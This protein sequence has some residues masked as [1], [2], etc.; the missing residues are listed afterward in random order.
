VIDGLELHHHPFA[1]H[2]ME[3]IL[4][5]LLRCSITHDVPQDPVL[6]SEGH[7]YSRRAIIEWIR[8][9]GTS[10]MTRASLRESDLKDMPILTSICGVISGFVT[11]GHQSLHCPTAA[12]DKS[13]IQMRAM[14]AVA[15]A[16][17]EA[18]AGIFGSFVFR[19]QILSSSIRAFYV[20][21]HETQVI[22]TRVYDSPRFHSD[23]YQ[24]RHFIPNDI[25]VFLPSSISKETLLESIR[26]CLKFIQV[27]ALV[28]DDGE[29]ESRYAQSKLST[30]LTKYTIEVPGASFESCLRF[31]MD[32]VS[33]STSTLETGAYPNVMKM[34]VQESAGT[35]S[36]SSNCGDVTGKVS[37]Y[38]L[39]ALR[40]LQKTM[41]TVTPFL[42]GKL[43]YPAFGGDA[44]DIFNEVRTYYYRLTKE[45][46]DEWTF[47][48]LSVHLDPCGTKACFTRAFNVDGGVCDVWDESDFD[49]D[50]ALERTSMHDLKRGRFHV[51][52]FDSSESM[53][54]HF[55]C[56]PDFDMRD[57]PV[58]TDL[59]F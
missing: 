12:L 10:P 58:L 56:D 19:E 48:N 5:V 43:S 15:K 29:N 50:D 30:K 57:H 4:G 41:D 6:S 31:G 8:R 20:E 36:M 40:S 42:K 55:L 32:V 34:L 33:C 47:L 49:L 45:L 54:V 18:G 13:R 7:V 59:N 23:S 28:G 1:K 17:R 35:I 21:C 14:L 44:T 9:R 39:R 53:F 46:R 37:E 27:T 26:L 25:D 2:A 52:K 38:S 51:Q 22:P 11:D 24:D 3:E 16:V